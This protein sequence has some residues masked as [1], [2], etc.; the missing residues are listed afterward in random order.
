MTLG[1]NDS[2]AA[3]ALQP[4]GRI[5][6]AGTT[7]AAAATDA[8]VARL[9]APAGTLD[10]SYGGGT[11]WSRLNL[12]GNESATAVALQPGDGRIVVAGDTNVAGTFDITV[13]R[14]LSPQGTFDS[15]YG[16]GFGWSRLDF[17]G[18]DLGGGVA[19]QPDGRIVV[20]GASDAG[21]SY[22]MAVARLLAPEGTFDPSFGAGANGRS[23]A[24]FGGTDIANAV[25]LQPDGRI[26][27][28]GSSDAA[29]IG[30]VA[31][32]RLL[33]G[34]RLDDSFGDGGKTLVDLGSG[35]AARAVALQPD[36]KILLAGSSG[37]TD[38]DDF[39]VVR[40]QPNGRPDTTFGTNGHSLVNFGG[41]DFARAVALQPDGGIVAVGYSV[42]G[43]KADI[44]VARLLGDPRPGAGGTGGAGGGTGSTAGPPRCGGRR[45]TIVGTAGRDV[46][47][48]TKRADVI[49]A[50]GGND[51]VRG[52]GGADLVCGGPGN[53]RIFGGPGADRLLGGPGADRLLGGAGADRLLAGPGADRLLGGPGRDLLSGGPGRD[54]QH[55]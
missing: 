25:T 52:G 54:A 43:G 5:V 9:L 39:A 7:S 8:A 37:D 23:L 20:A 4:D 51:V 55:Q 48:G 42:T 46:L 29:G 11:G 13:A 10:P 44:A 33:P 15:S 32:A 47:R 34:G 41:G 17:G 49:A 27:V 26:V 16:G 14:L 30:D 22:D 24:N 28:A 19:L 6:I 36:G 38:N 45:A 3:V 40:L 18:V 21:G 12:G 50:L 1:G 35:D 2:A 31:V 53:D